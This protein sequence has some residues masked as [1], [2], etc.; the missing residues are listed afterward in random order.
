MSIQTYF[1]GIVRQGR[2]GSPTL[3]EARRD[4]QDMLAR[5]TIVRLS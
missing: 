2:P 3:D 5:A 4:F 1:S